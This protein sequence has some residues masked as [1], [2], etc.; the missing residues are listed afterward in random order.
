MSER[1]MHEPLLELFLTQDIVPGIFGEDT[2]ELREDLF[3]LCRA[4][5]RAGWD[6]CSYE[7]YN[8]AMDAA[9]T[10]ASDWDY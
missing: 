5:Y 10:L 3:K 7:A 1:Y 6:D 9:N 4:Y 8:V 2:P